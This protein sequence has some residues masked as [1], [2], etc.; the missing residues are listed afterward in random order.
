VADHPLDSFSSRAGFYQTWHLADLDVE[1]REGAPHSKWAA[2]GFSLRGGATAGTELARGE[3][4]HLD[5]PFLGFNLPAF[6]ER[7]YRRFAWD[8]HWW[9][10]R[11]AARLGKLMGTQEALRQAQSALSEY[12]GDPDRAARK[13]SRY[14]DSVGSASAPLPPPHEAWQVRWREVDDDLV[15]AFDLLNEHH[16][17]LGEEH[18]GSHR[19][20]LEARNDQGKLFWRMISPTGP[21]PWKAGEGTQKIRLPVGGEGSR[22]QLI[23]TYRIRLLA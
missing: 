8:V 22:H 17:A 20:T 18:V 2:L 5:D 14:T 7:A 6:E 23:A 21:K 13:L 1:A 12:P 16:K 9:C 3:E 15:P 4:R 10:D 19:F 11:G